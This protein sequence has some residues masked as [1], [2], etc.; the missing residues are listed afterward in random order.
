[1][2]TNQN[3]KRKKSR[4]LSDPGHLA[5]LKAYYEDIE[6]SDKDISPRNKALRSLLTRIAIG[7]ALLGC[8]HPVWYVYLLFAA[9][10]GLI[11]FLACQNDN[12]ATTR[13]KEGRQG[14]K[15]ED[16]LEK[17]PLK[18][19]VFAKNQRPNGVVAK[20]KRLIVDYRVNSKSARSVRS[21]HRG[22]RRRL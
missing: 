2:G 7:F 8:A 15:E 20:T 12:N 10:A 9:I 5:E 11:T 14:P 21:I 6:E 16:G 22:K 18:P 1:M 3:Y 13:P 17:G 19:R 4:S